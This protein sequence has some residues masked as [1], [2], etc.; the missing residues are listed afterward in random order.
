MIII[1]AGVT[2]NII[3]GSVFFIGVLMTH[4]IRH[5]PG[6]VSTV[7]PGGPAW[8]KGLRSGA[9]IQQIGH[10][11]NPDYM[12]IITVIMTSREG[13][14]IPFVFRTFPDGQV[15]ETEIEPI[16]TEDSGKPIIGIMVNPPRKAQLA[17]RMRS[18]RAVPRGKSRGQVGGSAAFRRSDHLHVR[19]GRSV[20]NEAIAAGPA[21]P[22]KSSR[23]L[24]IGSAFSEVGGP[25]DPTRNPVRGATKKL[26]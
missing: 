4:G 14:Q 8:V 11:K 18:E 24:R 6:I 22:R 20:R 9:E 21:I 2:M 17:K 26:G 5:V 16:K 1:S 10:R 12:K 23:L 25:P 19:P 3:L 15:H 13:R 7:D